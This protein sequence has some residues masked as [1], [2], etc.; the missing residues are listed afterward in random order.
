MEQRFFTQEQFIKKYNEDVI[1]AD[2]VYNRM[3]ANGFTEN[4]LAVFD[5][6]YLS[7]SRQK[8]EQLGGLL[9]ESHQVTIKSIAE[10]EG[11]WEMEITTREFPVDHDNLLC[12]ALDLYIKGYEHDCRLDGYGTFAGADNKNFQDEDPALLEQYFNAA[13]DAYE[14]RNFGSAVINFTTTIRIFP[15]NANSWY[16]RAIAKEELFLNNMAKADYDK[17]IELSPTFKE[18]Y[19]N[20]AVNRFDAGDFTAA[21]ADFDKVVELDPSHAAA[22]FNRGNTKKAMGDGE[23]AEADWQQAKALGLENATERAN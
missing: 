14:N 22:Y 9:Q 20:R 7:N 19:I 21:L 3:L 6:Y 4:A 11:I 1:L 2:D 18:A 13:M 16:S 10:K 17:A 8:L 5:V 15:Q 12:W 23:G